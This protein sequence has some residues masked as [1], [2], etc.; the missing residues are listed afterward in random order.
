[1]LL[2]VPKFLL[3]F[4]A[5]QNRFPFPQK[6]LP[7]KGPPTPPLS[8]GVTNCRGNSKKKCGAMLH[9][10]YVGWQGG[11]KTLYRILHNFPMCCV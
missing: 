3:R 2:H 6:K 4:A 11:E 9:T 1:M 10:V 7:G 8:A 5:A